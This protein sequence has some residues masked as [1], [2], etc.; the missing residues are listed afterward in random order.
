MNHLRTIETVRITVAI[1]LFITLAGSGDSRGAPVLVNG[2]FE[3]GLSGWT[4]SDSAGS[5]GMFF[6][7]SGTTSPVNGDPVPAPSA[8]TFAAMTDAQGPGSHVLYQ[9]FVVPSSLSPTDSLIKFDLF[10]GNRAPFFATPTPASLDFG[11]NAF[12]Q[13]VRVDLLRGGT[14]P[15][16]VLPTDIVQNLYQSKPGDTLV[17]TSYR[18]FGVDVRASLLSNLG[19]TLRLRFSEVDNVETLQL[20]VDNVSF[21]S[22]PEP[23]SIVLSFIG[24]C[25]CI[26]YCVWRSGRS[27]KE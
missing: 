23:S 21:Q 2:S 25:S 27:V 20:G 10:I 6:S 19:Q 22:V 15:F 14:D 8:G 26:G 1:A 12:N 24:L 16:S 3:S 4:K 11:I 5:D 17:T 7:Q 18:T 13:Q 9:D